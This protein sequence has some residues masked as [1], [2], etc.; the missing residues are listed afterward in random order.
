MKKAGKNTWKFRQSS[1]VCGEAFVTNYV[2]NLDIEDT[3]ISYN[4]T[5]IKFIN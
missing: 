3:G 1:Y 4:D 5:N 2:W